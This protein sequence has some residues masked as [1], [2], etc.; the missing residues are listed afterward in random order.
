MSEDQSDLNW[1]SYRK[2]RNKCVKIRK[3]CIKD[4]LDINWIKI[5]MSI[6]KL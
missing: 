2:Q 6:E 5:D 3:K 4:Y 1:Q